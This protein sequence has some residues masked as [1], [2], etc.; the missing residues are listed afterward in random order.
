MIASCAI[1]SAISG[2]NTADV[3]RQRQGTRSRVSRS[4]TLIPTGK[5]LESDA[6]LLTWIRLI[7]AQEIMS[8]SRAA[9]SAR[10]PV[11][12]HVSG[13]SRRGKRRSRHQNQKRS[14]EHGTP[15][16]QHVY[17]AMDSPVRY[18][19]IRKM[20]RATVATAMSHVAG[21]VRGMGNVSWNVTVRHR[22][23][24]SLNPYRVN[25]IR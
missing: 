18:R 9:R 19:T 5:R 1:Y 11:G 21:S 2:R 13:Q 17:T 6:N 25:R 8:R 4:T 24:R 15:L 16:P 23:Q 12:M 20:Y 7:T 3:W 14:P 22:G 10:I